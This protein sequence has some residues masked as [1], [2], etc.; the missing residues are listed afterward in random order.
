MQESMLPVTQSGAVVWSLRLL[1]PRGNRHPVILL[2][3]LI[4]VG[5]VSK[6]DRHPNWELYAV[7]KE[8]S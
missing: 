5:Q 2:L 1:L 8:H 4:D 7:Y 3:A 6:V